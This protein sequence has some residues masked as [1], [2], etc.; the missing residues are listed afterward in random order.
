MQRDAKGRFVKGSVP[1]NKGIKRGSVSKA[2][3]FK[4]GIIPHNFKGIG[5]PHK[6]QPHR[7]EVCCSFNETV[8][9]SQGSR[10]KFRVKKRGYYARYLWEERYGKVPDGYV[11]YNNGDWRHP[12]I[13]NLEC[14]TRA[15]LLRRNK[16]SKNIF[17]NNNR[18]G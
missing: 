2:T 13:E 12:K 15:E 11:I 18:R 10:G 5:V 16:L 4:P 6:I 1:Y 9:V 7:K 8:E 3:E 17:K 14:I